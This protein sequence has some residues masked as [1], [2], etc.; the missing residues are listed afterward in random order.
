M[1][2]NTHDDTGKECAYCTS[3]EGVLINDICK[4]KGSMYFHEKC[5]FHMLRINH[6]TSCPTCKENIN[7]FTGYRYYE[8]RMTPIVIC[9]LVYANIPAL[10][11]GLVYLIED[12]FKYLLIHLFSFPS[13]IGKCDNG[14]W[15]FRRIKSATFG[16]IFI[17]QLYRTF[18]DPHEKLLMLTQ[19]I[20]WVCGIILCGV[21]WVMM[22]LK[23][24][25]TIFTVFGFTICVL[26]D[27]IGHQTKHIVPIAAVV[28]PIVVYFT[29]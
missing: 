16:M 26:P 29:Y 17:L 18:T 9:L 7:T 6:T 28:T 8:H 10:Y 14:E 27:M 24:V 13:S 15:N 2:S 12:L 23:I 25:G 3:D 22:F 20:H 19:H 11:V 1:S 4:C 21:Y 5:V